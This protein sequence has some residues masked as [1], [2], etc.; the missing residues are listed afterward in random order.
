[1]RVVRL[2]VRGP[3]LAKYREGRRRLLAYGADCFPVQASSSMLAVN[4]ESER[5]HAIMVLPVDG[6]FLTRVRPC[7]L[8]NPL[9][10]RSE[11]LRGHHALGGDPVL[12]AEAA[13]AG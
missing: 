9:P 1:M 7:S 2:I 10:V 13:K 6:Y 4:F 12:F 11:G 3:A 8:A 5:Q